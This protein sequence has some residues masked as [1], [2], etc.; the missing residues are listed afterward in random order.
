MYAR[1][2]RFVTACDTIPLAA[3]GGT[4][5]FNA[6]A[7]Q[8]GRLVAVEFEFVAD[9]ATVD[10]ALNDLVVLHGS[11]FRLL[12]GGRVVV[13][14]RVPVGELPANE[15]VVA[16]ELHVMD[17]TWGALVAAAILRTRFTY[18]V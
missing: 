1:P 7:P 14:G 17:L 11:S 6:Q 16:G 5:S 15:E 10:A 2:A 8:E 9:G 13:T 18:A 4:A 3:V 12:V